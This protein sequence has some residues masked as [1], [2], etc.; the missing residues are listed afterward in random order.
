M[1]SP[2]RTMSGTQEAPASPRTV[3]NWAHSS[4]SCVTS[5]GGVACSV[6]GQRNHMRVPRS[7]R[8]GRGHLGQVQR[9]GSLP[10]P[11]EGA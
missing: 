3:L 1:P 5:G 6:R 11:G 10:H 9:K 4:R 8:P 2:A 7:G